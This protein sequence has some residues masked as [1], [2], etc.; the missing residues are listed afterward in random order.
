MGPALLDGALVVDDRAAVTTIVEALLRDPGPP[1]GPAF[2]P[3]IATSVDEAVRLLASGPQGSGPL[4]PGRGPIRVV[5]LSA[6]LAA[7]P[8]MSALPLVRAA[9][10][11][12]IVILADTDDELLA[13][14]AC[15]QGA[16]D[17]VLREGLDRTL[18]GRTLRYAV[19]RRD[20]EVELEE[21]K[22]V[23]RTLLLRVKGVAY[24]TAAVGRWRLEWAGENFADVVGYPRSLFM[25]SET[26]APPAMRF[27]DIILEQDRASVLRIVNQAV[28][29][30]AP[31]HVVFRIRRADGG[32]RWL[33]AHGEG[34]FDARGVLV[35]REGVLTDVTAQQETQR[36][37]RAK[38]AQL[39]QAQKLEAVGRLAGG[40]A[41][42]FNNVLGAMV[43]HA[44]VALSELSD[45]GLTGEHVA[46]QE[47]ADLLTA[48]TR[49][50][51]LTRQLLLFSRRQV[52]QPAILSL[53]SVVADLH[54]LLRRTL[55]I[56]V[57]ITQQLDADH[58]WVFVDRSQVEQ[59]VMNLAVN[60]R[61]A[62]PNGGTLTIRT[63]TVEIGGER[64]LVEPAN[65]VLIG[66]PLTPGR[67]VTL[68]VADVGH[69]MTVET[70]HRIFDPFF[71]TKPI[72]HGTGLGLA[73]VYGVVTDA[74]GAIRVTSRLHEG[75]EF[76]VYLPAHEAP[77]AKAAQAPL[78][79][80]PG[81]TETILLV[82]DEPGMSRSLA[83]ILRRRGYTV[84]TAG[85]VGEALRLLAQL[86][87][88]VD[89][90]LSDVMMPGLPGDVLVRALLARTPRPRILLM[91][92]N[93][94]G[95]GTDMD[96]LLPGEEDITTQ[97]D[98]FIEKPASIDTLLR[99]IRATL[100]EAPP[101]H[102][103]LASAP[104]P[105]AR[106]D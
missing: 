79:E 98:G 101:L 60:A 34:V 30:G 49:A 32:L 86:K 35:A 16:A 3:V 67:Y 66:G 69:G 99:T 7:M 80:R 23:Y 59:I 52:P 51:H 44:E 33:E 40:I 82:D 94:R 28:Q 37:L 93:A 13:L 72:G 4:A 97:V 84:H 63:G 47:L 11:V 90:V 14:R 6:E 36:A 83:H 104:P 62:M 102:G 1:S 87:H 50:G 21:Q 19:E 55:G 56:D 12:P 96:R 95:I 100:D 5:L 9:T 54:R 20:A 88:A 105:P 74:R 78:E 18:L 106:K 53:N 8:L 58:P 10:P 26:G 89:L 29:S 76:T 24:R 61:D 64:R 85:D 41:H 46:V 45:V 39:R 43:A 31:Y 77:A 71:T 73:T 68:V 25:E 2:H 65:G 27:T 38:E 42:D 17:Y 57:D 91:S 75:A 92:G 81:G 22:R 103:A 15:R 48:A 70:M